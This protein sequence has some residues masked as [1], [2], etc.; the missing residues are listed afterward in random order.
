[1]PAALLR[2]C[3]HPG[4]C[5]KLVEK[6]RCADHTKQAERVSGTST[7]RGYDWK[8]RGASRRFLRK[9]PLCGMRPDGLEPVMSECHANGIATQATQT[10]HVIPHKGD[11][12]RFWAERENWQALCASCGGRKSRAGL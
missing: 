8:W 12:R 3:S 6:G 2:N 5:E 9:Y 11:K 4:G 7:E 1:M 10:D